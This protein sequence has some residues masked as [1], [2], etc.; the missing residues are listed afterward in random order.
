MY[1]VVFLSGEGKRI[2][3][4]FVEY[5]QARNFFFRCKYSKRVKVVSYNFNPFR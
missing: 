3:K 4:Q 1:T 5:P 2:V